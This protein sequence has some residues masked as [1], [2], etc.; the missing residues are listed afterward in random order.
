METKSFEFPEWRY[1]T[2]KKS[3]LVTMCGR[4]QN[5]FFNSSRLLLPN[6]P[7]QIRFD[8]SDSPAS[9]VATKD[10][11]ERFK[12]DIR[13]CTLFMKKVKI[14]PQVVANISQAQ[15]PASSVSI[16]A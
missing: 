13:S 12:I 6:I 7:L 4:L 2:I 15:S 14:A 8:R 16:Y 5:D 11:T 1:E 9:L 10:V 3:R